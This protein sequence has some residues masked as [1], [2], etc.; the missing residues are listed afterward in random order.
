[1]VATV[2]RRQNVAR[3][4]LGLIRLV[5]GLLALLAPTLLLRQ[6]RVDPQLE[7]AAKYPF[8][9]FGIRTVLIAADL[10]LNRGPARADAVRLAPIIHVSDT[11][12]AAIAGIRGELPRRAAITATLISTVNV[13]LS[14]AAQPRRAA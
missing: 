13:A 2:E 7:A 10:L 4:S 1:M 14:L 6:L 12:S 9:L 3:I 8:R 5:N 11:I